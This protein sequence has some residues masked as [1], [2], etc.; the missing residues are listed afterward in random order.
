MNNANWNK[1]S[2]ATL[3]GLILVVLGIAAFLVMEGGSIFA[4]PHGYVMLGIAALIVI[5]GIVFVVLVAKGKF[6][7]REPDYK[8]FFI[9]GICWL[10][11]GIATDNYAF[12]VMGLAFMI[13]ALL[14][15]T[16]GITSQSGTNFRRRKRS[17]K[18][19]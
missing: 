16:N 11:L 8:T 9:L 12:L 2:I 4:S 13:F 19:P 6:V 18:L 10:P 1:V 7:Q 3:I 15:R 14:T 5:I 17:L